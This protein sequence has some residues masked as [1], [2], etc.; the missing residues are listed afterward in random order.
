[1]VPRGDYQGLARE[2]L[3]LLND[4]VLGER[5]T[6]AAKL[7]CQRYSWEAVRTQWLELYKELAG[8]RQKEAVGSR[9]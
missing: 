9:Q 5:L 4:Q 3:R 2:A 7:E 6:R 8:R 1:M